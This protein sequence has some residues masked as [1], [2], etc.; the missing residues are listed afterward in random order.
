MRPPILYLTVAFA[1]GLVAGLNG[2]ELRVTALP[3]FLGALVLS[4]RAPLGAALG[5]MF[6]AGTLWGGAAVRERQATCAGLWGSG[7]GD[8]G[9]VTRAALVRLTDPVPAA[10]GTVE[11]D[12]H[13]GSCGGTL[14][15]RWPQGYA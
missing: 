12:V 6:A 10:G 3:V 14:R 1:A 4:R 11:G 8:A 7:K 13:G 15:I 9:R 5:V 2:A